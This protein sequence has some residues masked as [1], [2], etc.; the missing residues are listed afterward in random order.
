MPGAREF[1]YRYQSFLTGNTTSPVSSSDLRL[2]RTR[3]QPSDTAA[4]IFAS[5]RSIEWVML[6]YING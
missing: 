5:S 4:M 1:Q 3:G 6:S 2:D